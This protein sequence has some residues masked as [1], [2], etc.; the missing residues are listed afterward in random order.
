MTRIIT[1]RQLF[2][3][4]PDMD[5]Y[6]PHSLKRRGLLE[7]EP[8]GGWLPHRAE[9]IHRVDQ[10]KKALKCGTSEALRMAVDEPGFEVLLVR[11][12][13]Q[14]PFDRARGLLSGSTDAI[15]VALVTGKIDLITMLTGPRPLMFDAIGVLLHALQP[16]GSVS[17]LACT[18]VALKGYAQLGN[19]MSR[20]GRTNGM[21]TLVLV[22]APDSTS[23][24]FLEA[25]KPINEVIVAGEIF[26]EWDG[27]VLVSTD[28]LER[29]EDIL[30]N[31]IKSIPTVVD[32]ETHIVLPTF[33]HIALPEQ[34]DS[35]WRQYQGP[36]R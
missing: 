32:T 28:D 35:I 7:S 12:V 23:G 17:Y 29:L 2:R 16:Q 31:E 26:G 5:R 27:F 19:L 22:K 20:E 18:Q 3:R 34:L 33:F 9:I 13:P 6:L 24:N 15:F 11:G 10:I 25:V 14:R 8:S 36:H 30:L 4:F 1:N 21:V